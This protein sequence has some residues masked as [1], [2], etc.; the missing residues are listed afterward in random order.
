MDAAKRASPHNSFLE[1]RP[2][3]WLPLLLPLL[4]HAHFGG[5]VCSGYPNWQRSHIVAQC[6]KDG[7]KSGIEIDG[8]GSRIGIGIS[9][10]GAPW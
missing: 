4:D 9:S 10:A 2:A 3:W 8:D 5:S 7:Q 1:E 6:A